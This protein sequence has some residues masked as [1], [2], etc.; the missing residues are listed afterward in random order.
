MADHQ[1]V[2]ED[3]VQTIENLPG[4]MVH[5]FGEIRDKDTEFQNLKT[6]I[7]NRDMH[8]RRTIKAGPVEPP[9]A[10]VGSLAN[11]KL[12]TSAGGGTSSSVKEEAGTPSA[13]ASSTAA[14]GSASGPAGNPSSASS[15]TK[16]ERKAVAPSPAG[17]PAAANGSSAVIL[18]GAGSGSGSA[19]AAP[20]GDTALTGAKA[21]E[22]FPEQRAL[23][24]EIMGMYSE[25]T[26]IADEKLRLV[27]RCILNIDRHIRKLNI[28]LETIARQDGTTTLADGASSSVLS[29]LVPSLSSITTNRTFSSLS[30]FQT[31]SSLSATTTPLPLAPPLSLASR[32]AS[33]MSDGLPEP[34]SSSA[35]E[36]PLKRVEAAEKF[37]RAA[38]S[39]VPVTPAVLAKANLLKRRASNMRVTP[40]HQ[41]TMK[42]NTKRKTAEEEFRG[43]APEVDEQ[44]YCFCRQVSYGEMIACDSDSCVNEWFHL[45]CVGL[46]ESPKNEVWYCPDCKALLEEEDEDFTMRRAH[47]KKKV[48]D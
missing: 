27:E 36:T 5:I 25:G 38:A 29:T 16:K 48:R 11:I 4:E 2:L 31:P 20:A 33:S 3:F 42:K 35:V 8:L 19:V 7:E 17:D 1:Q 44:L 13:K 41:K 15:P 6:R 23:F 12:E 34:S 45:E 9:S 39:P 30:Q 10:V 32:L 22:P 26:A 47:K 43:T 14:S 46:T 28:D 37:E 24:A 18:A 21:V 40:A